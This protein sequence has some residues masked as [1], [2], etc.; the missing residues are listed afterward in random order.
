MARK[1]D[2]TGQRFGRLTVTGLGERINDRKA[3]NCTCECGTKVTIRQYSLTGGNTNS[4]GCLNKELVSEL[5]KKNAVDEVCNK[6]GRLTV[7]KKANVQDNSH[8]K[9]LCECICGNKT[10]VDS[11]NLRS[12]RVKSCG[13]LSREVARETILETNSKREYTSETIKYAH[14]SLRLKE[15]TSLTMIGKSETTA[16]SGVRGVYWNKS[17]NMWVAQL[18]LKGTR[19]LD[20]AFSNKQDAINARKEAEEEYFKPILEKYEQK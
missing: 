15:G 11:S 5:G 18:T 3:W 12:G 1:I 4:C 13:C 16:K 19:L 2:L 7:I 20:K 6:Y 17:L 14:E 8:V 9:W 10:I